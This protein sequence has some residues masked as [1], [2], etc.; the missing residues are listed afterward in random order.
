MQVRLRYHAARE[1]T[2]GHDRGHE[3]RLHAVAEYSAEASSQALAGGTQTSSESS[4]SERFTPPH[5]KSLLPFPVPEWNLSTSARQCAFTNFQCGNISAHRPVVRR[6]PRRP[7][8][9]GSA[10]PH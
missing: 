6:P 4:A 7:G 5:T 3:L 8:L 10:R 2:T 1:K 9:D